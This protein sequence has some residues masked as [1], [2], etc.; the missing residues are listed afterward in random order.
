MQIPGAAEPQPGRTEN[1]IQQPTLAHT[2]GSASEISKN[3]QRLNAFTDSTLERL[4]RARRSV[5]TRW[6]IEKAERVVELR[7]QRRARLALLNPSVE[8]LPLELARLTAEGSPKDA[9]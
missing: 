7:I 9:S 2:H 8:S 5:R 4:D 3:R 1:K 6:G